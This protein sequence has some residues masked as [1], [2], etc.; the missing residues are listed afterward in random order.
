[1][2]GSGEQQP[3]SVRDKEGL[4]HAIGRILGEG[5][6]LTNP[7]ITMIAPYYGMN[8][9]SDLMYN[10]GARKVMEEVGVVPRRSDYKGRK[11][12]VDGSRELIPEELA[13]VYK[14]IDEKNKNK[15]SS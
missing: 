6:V 1:M 11:V 13:K 15:N 5:Y 12:F 9:S 4:C 2:E 10:P 8:P 14:D 7:D 3:K